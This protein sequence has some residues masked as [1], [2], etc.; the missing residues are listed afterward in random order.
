[1]KYGLKHA[2][3]FPN[4]GCMPR[5]T[6]INSKTQRRRSPMPV[7]YLHWRENRQSYVYRPNKNQSYALTTTVTAS[8]HLKAKYKKGD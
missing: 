4:D 6:E 2:P 1:M 3:T 7:L 5:R 8:K